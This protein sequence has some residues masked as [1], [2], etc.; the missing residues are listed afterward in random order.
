MP[1]SD[2]CGKRLISDAPKKSFFFGKNPVY[3]YIFNDSICE[4]STM[5]I[6]QQL[7]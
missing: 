7:L 4:S 6:K 1:L 5:Y 2:G 3:V